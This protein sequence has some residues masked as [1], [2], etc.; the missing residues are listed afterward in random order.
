MPCSIRWSSAV[1]VLCYPGKSRLQVP[2]ALF[3]THETFRWSSRKK[4]WSCRCEMIVALKAFLDF[5][6]QTILAHHRR[7]SAC[8]PA[9]LILPTNILWH[10]HAVKSANESYS[11]KLCL[12]TTV[13]KFLFKLKCSR[14]HRAISF[15]SNQCV[16]HGHDPQPVAGFLPSC[17]LITCYQWILFVCRMFQS[18][19]FGFWRN[20]FYF[21]FF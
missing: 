12:L 11:N 2:S 4:I 14:V 5:H 9:F 7:A 20:L 8:D 19:G 10:C 17:S 15:L 18:A 13:L 21:L 1:L 6:T 16:W 3:R